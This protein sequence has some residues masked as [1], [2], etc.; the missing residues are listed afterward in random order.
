MAKHHIVDH[1]AWIA[2]RTRFLA[3]E[4]EFT[5]LRDELSRE[6]QDLPWER[7][8]KQYIFESENGK[9]TLADLFGKH[10][11]LIVYHFMFDPDWEMGCPSCSFW[12]DN[13]N[14]II[15]HLNQRD[16]AMVAVSRAPLHKLR[17]QARK[18]GWTFKW[19]SSSDSDFNFD[20]KV[21]FSPEDVAEGEAYYNF[22]TQ[23]VT[24][25]CHTSKAATELPGI[26]AFFKDGD[27]I[28][29][30]YSTY[31]R[32][33]DMFNTAYHY[34]DMAPKGRDEDALSFPMSWVKYRT[35]YEH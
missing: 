25:D 35:A 6:R 12:A 32:G 33:V 18:L 16:V 15:P 11:Q 24:R 26:S 9:E 1:E 30:T 22:G 28:Y 19:V 20:Y 7:V 31:S 17:A 5:H 10:S 23:K 21:S 2:A 34:L 4:K 27:Q 13:F 29:H 14:G 3:R 8:E